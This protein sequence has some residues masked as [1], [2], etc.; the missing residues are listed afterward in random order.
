MK[1]N[2]QQYFKKT[3]YKLLAGGLAGVC[4]IG[5]SCSQKFLNKPALG[6]LSQATLSN[7]AGVK[8][9]LIGAY[10]LLDG[11]GSINQGDQYGSGASNW[12]YGNVCAIDAY[13]GSTPSDQGDIAALETW[14]TNTGANSYP[15]QRWVALYD[16]IQRSNDVI[17][18]MA[19]ATDISAGDH[20]ELMAE[21]RFLRGLYHFE[22]K[23]MWKNIPYVPETV[24]ASSNNVNVPNKVDCWPQIE[25]DFKFAMDSLL[26]KQTDIGRANKYAA[27]AFLAKCYMFQYKYDSA[28]T[29]LTDIMANGV[30]SAGVAFGFNPGGYS[31]NFNP[32]PTAKNSS[33]SV[34]SVQMSVNDGS[35]TNG[36]YGDVLNFPNDGSGP[37]GCCGF[38]NPSI[39]LSMAYKTDPTTGLPLFT[40]YNSGAIPKDSSY[41]GTLDPR[42]DFVMGRAGVP[43]L[44]WG[45]DRGSLWIRD[46]SDGYYSPKKNV[47]A[48]SQKGTY[49]SNETS[50]WGPTQIDANNVNMIRYS[51]VL[52]W[53]AECQVEIGDP[54]QA[55]LLVN[56]VR[57]R[58]KNHPETW[59]YAGATFNASTY[60][61]AAGG[62]QAGN[63]L[64][65]DYPAGSFAADKNYAMNAIRWERRLELA[66]EGHYFF[67]LARYNFDPTYPQDMS[68]WI[69]TT[70]AVEATRSDI[71]SVNTGAT[72]HKGI[73]EYFPI[74]LTEIDLENATGTQN[75]IQNPGYQ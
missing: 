2:Y 74:P 52:L 53:M 57:D 22:A 39:N 16:G 44:D 7:E 37:G 24:S 12:V 49:S 51:D 30:N 5:F 64:I 61:Y 21:A 58:V 15:E 69:N 63:Y 46:G 1:S 40:T 25:N 62:T 59:V 17:R 36:D 47:Y 73:N 31:N 20:G 66:M 41:A 14:Q 42:I 33:E 70:V 54:E 68:V 8:S 60:T 26:V 32:A 4:I 55:R 13:K 11:E 38:D 43:Y 19:L 56:Q 28:M 75:L 35:G 18:T 45:H 65:G 72:F 50:F 27:E 71:Y 29:L 23:K 9:L 3:K 6:S 48:L 67:D 34:F 10:S